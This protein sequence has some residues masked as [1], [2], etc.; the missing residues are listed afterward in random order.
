MQMGLCCCG[1]QSSSVPPSSSESSSSSS[2]SSSSSSVFSGSTFSNTCADGKCIDGVLAVRYELSHSISFTSTAGVCSC[3]LGTF[4]QGMILENVGSCS[5]N[6]SEREQDITLNSPT[7]GAC[8]LSNLS[9][10][11]V[12][13]LFDT[14]TPG[15]P[16]IGFTVRVRLYAWQGGSK[17]ATWLYELYSTTPINCLDAISVPFVSVSHTGGGTF[18][19][20][21][22][23]TGE[24]SDIILTP[25]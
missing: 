5:Y 2:G 13:L 24:T 17:R 22:V 21:L 20:C 19:N 15:F 23:T 14:G 8:T 6:T 7:A 11:R 18:P 12:D 4:P 25:V 1:R 16:L 9:G 3:I 10:P